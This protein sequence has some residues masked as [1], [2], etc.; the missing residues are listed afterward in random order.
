MNEARASLMRKLLADAGNPVNLLEI[1]FW[2]GKSS[3]YF[4][5]MLEDRGEGH[6]TTIDRGLAAR[7]TPN[8][9]T[10]LDALGLSH[11]VTPIFAHRSHTWELAR[12][13]RQSPRPQFDFCYFDGGHTWDTTGYG[14]LLVDML[15]KP[16]ATLVVDDLDWTINGSLERHPKAEKEYA[17]YDEEERQATAVQMAF[18]LIL[19][20]LGYTHM[21][22]EKRFSWGIARKPLQA[23][24]A[25]RGLFGRG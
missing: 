21:R 8:I 1:G 22:V 15:L 5:A 4:A 10:V 12:L 2:K 3:A 19:P 23:T 16:G 24:P 18:D 25:R 9:H 6:L 13:I 14:L 20:R 17:G 11:R 7:K